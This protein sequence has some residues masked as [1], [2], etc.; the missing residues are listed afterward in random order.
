MHP[1][2]HHHREDRDH[3]HPAP[4]PDEAAYEA[5][6]KAQKKVAGVA[7]C[8]KPLTSFSLSTLSTTFSGFGIGARHH[9]QSGRDYDQAE[10]DSEEVSG[11]VGRHGASEES[12]D[13]AG[14]A[15]EEAGS[16][17][18]RTPPVMAL[19]GVD[20]GGKGHSESGPKRDPGGHGRLDPHGGQNPELDRH[21]DGAASDPQ[22]PG[23]EARSDS[24]DQKG[25]GVDEF[26]K[27]RF[28]GIR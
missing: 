14:D 26:H 6:G 18:D 15:E 17:D 21:H 24:C 13:E 16:R 27:M 4:D 23:G 22:H 3:D 5:E 20:G 11:C 10:D 7:P 9:P 1:K 19:G 2:A 25:E 8:N 28:D 12:A